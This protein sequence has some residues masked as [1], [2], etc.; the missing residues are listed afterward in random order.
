MLNQGGRQQERS[1]IPFVNDPICQRSH[2]STRELNIRTGICQRSHLSTLTGLPPVSRHPPKHTNT[3]PM[4]NLCC[5]GSNN[6]HKS[7]S[8]RRKG[9]K[10]G[11][12]KADLDMS[13]RMKA[14]TEKRDE[15]LN[16]DVEGQ[17]LAKLLTTVRE[18][19]GADSQEYNGFRELLV[20]GMFVEELQAR[21]E[22]LEQG[23]VKY[24]PDSPE[25]SAYRDKVLYNPNAGG[26]GSAA[27]VAAVA[28]AA[29]TLDA[30]QGEGDEHHK[31]KKKKK[32]KKKHK[33]H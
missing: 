2:L 11:A 7:G 6:R 21:F 16:K 33:H 20:A 25:Y 15:Q 9:T 22:S 8:M 28:P 30:S 1:S 5:M 14:F 13:N 26:R 32:K 4:G 3:I 18:T 24:P 17:L 12:N 29:A 27:P 23:S 31:K 19:Y 10:V